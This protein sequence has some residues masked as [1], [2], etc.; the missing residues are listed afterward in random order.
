[1]SRLPQVLDHPNP[2]P[3]V[4]QAYED[5]LHIEDELTAHQEDRAQ[6]LVERKRVV[7]VRILGYFLREGPTDTAIRYVA[8]GVVECERDVERIV[9]LGEYY[10]KWFIRPFRNAETSFQD[11]SPLRRF[12]SEYSS[13][14]EHGEAKA[15]LLTHPRDSDEAREA[16][17]I[18]DDWR[19]VLSRTVD[20]S[21]YHEDHEAFPPPPKGEKHMIST[22]TVHHIVPIL[23]KPQTFA[24]FAS[25]GY[26]S[27]EEELG[28]ER[29]H[30]LKNLMTVETSVQPPLDEQCMWFQPIEG[31]PN[32]YR[33]EIRAADRVLP[34]H[35]EQWRVPEILEFGTER[36]ELDLPCPRL[37]ALHAAGA[38]VA[39]SSGLYDFLEEVDAMVLASN[40]DAPSADLL[41][42]KLT[43]VVVD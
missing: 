40:A 1:M 27:L 10:D 24:V 25:F 6:N 31:V 11:S 13:L 23:T 19:C 33:R 20:Y 22:T 29:I 8:L 3:L 38:K 32:S 9:M 21:S 5:C 37:L 26:P 30:S 15:K 16:A 34:H 17:L 39:Q 41:A 12:K 35:L 42:V 4:T 43:N 14:K 28:E 36:P 18:R 7:N 2:T